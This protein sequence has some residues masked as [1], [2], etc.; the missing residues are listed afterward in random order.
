MAA[1]M[2]KFENYL[3]STKIVP[4]NRVPY[5]VSWISRFFAYHDKAYDDPVNGDEIS[6]FAHELGK[7]HEEWQVNQARE[8][9]G[10]K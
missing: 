6:R 7:N 8:R 2:K 5:Y 3:K 9:P 10:S 1:H 4:M